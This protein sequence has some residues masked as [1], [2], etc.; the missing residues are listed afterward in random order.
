MPGLFLYSLSNQ[1]VR[2]PTLHYFIKRNISKKLFFSLLSI[3]YTRTRLATDAKNASGQRQFN[4]IIDVYV[5]T[6]KTDGVRGLYRGF[7]V[8]TII[9]IL[10]GLNLFLRTVFQI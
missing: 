7:V 5:K 2:Q 8:S 3:D 10:Q 1:L 4:G 9:L 6:V